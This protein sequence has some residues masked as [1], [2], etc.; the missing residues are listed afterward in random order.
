M[1]SWQILVRAQ[2]VDDWG[3][4]EKDYIWNPSTCDCECN[5]TWKS[6][7][8][9]NTKSCSWKKRLIDKLVLACEGEILTKTK[10]SLGDEKVTCDEISF[11]VH[12]ILL[13]IICLIL[14]VS[15]S[16]SKWTSNIK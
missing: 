1:E 12:N 7:R 9:K 13:I 15:V 14:I 16:I 6:V 10:I 4:C 5:K 3:S 2:N 11:L 8:N